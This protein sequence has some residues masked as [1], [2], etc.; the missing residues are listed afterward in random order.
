MF[1]DIITYAII[2]AATLSGAVI[3]WDFQRKQR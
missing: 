3:V 1:V 2:A